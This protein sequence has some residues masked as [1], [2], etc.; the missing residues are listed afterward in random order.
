VSVFLLIC[1]WTSASA[2]T[3]EVAPGDDLNSLFSGLQAGDEVV[4]SDGVYP[5]ASGLTVSGIVGTLDNP[6]VLRAADGALPVLQLQLPVDASPPSSVL[7]L[8]ASQGI[9]VIGLSIEGDTTWEDLGDYNG[10]T[11]A[12]SS[13]I[14]LDGLEI[15]HVARSGIRIDG[16]SSSISAVG[17]HIHDTR[18][19]SGVRVGCSDASC[20]TSGF[21]FDLGWIHDIGAEGYGIELYHGSQAASITHTVMHD[22]L[23][24][25]VYLGSTESGD[26]NVLE[27]N[28]IWNVT[29]HGVVLNGA[30]RVRNNIIFNIG[31]EGVAGR[32]P[33]RGTFT[34]I[35][36]SHN[37]VTATTSWGMNLEGWVAETAAV[38]TNNSICNPVGLGLRVYVEPSPVEGVEPV[39]PGYVRN[40]VVCGYSEGVEE[41]DGELLLGGGL[42]DFTDAELWDFYPAEGSALLD[43]ADPTSAAWVTETDFN[44]VAREGDKP[45]VGA[46]EWDGEGNPGW[47]IREDFKD[48]TLEEEELAKAVTAGCC[49]EDGTE[50]GLL[51]APMLGIASLL[52]RRRTDP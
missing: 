52:R 32:D 51:I 13:A 8:E 5:L 46:Y 19:G 2:G 28:V 12:D 30:A 45:D 22:L 38:L 37:T 25:G 49:S 50:A 20:F 16:L 6:L 48:L 11:I 3:H 33:A 36:I 34:D 35:V 15:G 27:N 47:A 9:R 40:N 18:G 10:L 17:V 43:V 24:R 1:A 31:G 44:G 21:S 7:R 23:Y 29:E 39:T 4:F 14:E 42:G 41:G 26:A